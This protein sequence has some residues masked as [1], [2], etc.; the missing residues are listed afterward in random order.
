MSSSGIK[1]GAA[2]VELSVNDSKLTSGLDSAKK[3]LAGF[4]AGVNAIGASLTGSLSAV[5][6]KLESWGAA[7]TQSGTAMVAAGGA[8]SAALTGAAK[9]AADMAS[10]L[11]ATSARTE[12]STDA[13]QEL[14]YAADASGTSM[15]DLE[16]G[17]KHLKENIGEA[18]IG[19]DEAFLAFTRLG[20]SVND[21][22]RMSPDK[23][24][25]LMA[26]KLS[27]IEDPSIR[28]A[29]AAKVFGKTAERL[30]PLMAGGAA[31]IDRLRLAAR[32]LGIV[33]ARDDIDAA[34]KFSGEMAAMWKVIK[35]GVFQIGSALIPSL[36]EMV[37]NIV[38]AAKTATDWIKQNKGWV[39]SISKI[40]S[41]V[42]WAGA[43]FIVLG[44][45]L[46]GAATALGGVIGVISIVTTVLAGLLTPIGLVI[47]AFGG[48]AAFFLIKAGAINQAVDFLGAT[49]KMLLGD[50]TAAF[51]GIKAALTKG[52]IGLAAKIVWA[53]VKLEFARG[54]AFLRGLW[55]DF[56]AF[57]NTAWDFAAAKLTEAVF[58]SVKTLVDI[59]GKLRI[60]WSDAIG[61]LSETWETFAA[62][63][64]KT[65]NYVVG[66]IKKSI[67]DIKASITPAALAGFA[68]DTKGQ[69]NEI[70]KDTR[71]KNRIVDGDSAINIRD[72]RRQHDARNQKIDADQGIMQAGIGAAQQLFKPPGSPLG[73]GA[74]ADGPGS[75]VVKAADEL[76]GALDRAKI[77]IEKFVEMTDFANGVPNE[78][79]DQL[80]EASSQT[81]ADAKSVGTFSTVGA[82]M[83]GSG[84]TLS[85]IKENTKQAA[86]WAK[87]QADNFRKF[88]KI[89]AVNR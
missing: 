48:A 62:K 29:L 5:R 3:R 2:Y 26:D 35:V 84:G 63:V 81:V 57:F 33:I 68:V 77:K 13:L 16:H 22:R 64:L 88:G 14:G 8:V 11:V 10:E 18:A 39:V 56:T 66:E 80:K 70:D 49:F 74:R 19:S 25:G 89:R 21:L 54:V 20:V 23:Q 38:W 52:D 60:G 71:D 45:V 32:N 12:I 1:A 28:A 76:A 58:A 50:A 4:A 59:W 40:A 46:S 85:E 27:Q 69:K 17:L 65:W 82:G 43:G 6:D 73:A 30:A 41:V 31:G 15:E 9:S 24:F 72:H 67:A 7:L 61:F 34:D 55:A 75:E 47:A 36:R 86:K 83:I 42:T 53:V 79:A 51:E 87:V 78:K 37:A 44:T